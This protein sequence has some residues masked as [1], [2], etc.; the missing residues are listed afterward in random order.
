VTVRGENKPRG[1]EKSKVTV[2]TQKLSIVGRLN[3]TADFSPLSMGAKTIGPGG[4][5]AFTVCCPGNKDGG[6]KLRVRV[7]GEDHP[8]GETVR[9]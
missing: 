1:G 3:C 4:G 8:A 6:R 9:N 7:E 2:V 5:G